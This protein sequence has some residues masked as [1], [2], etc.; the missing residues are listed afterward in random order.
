MKPDW[1]IAQVYVVPALFCLL[2][3]VPHLLG[4]G[5]HGIGAVMLAVWAGVNVARTVRTRPTPGSAP[6]TVGLW[7]VTGLN[8]AVVWLAGTLGGLVGGG[9]LAF[10]AALTFAGAA[11]LALG[12]W[13]PPRRWRRALDEAARRVRSTL[14]RPVMGGA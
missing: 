10:A 8:F 12:H 9:D 2:A 6:H 14:S 13:R 4:S 5:L 1:T 3:G 11:W 7:R